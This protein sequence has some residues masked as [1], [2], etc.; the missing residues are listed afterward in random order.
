M[1][2]H[3]AAAPVHGY[4]LSQVF[5]MAVDNNGKTVVGDG[6]SFQGAHQLKGN[7]IANTPLEWFSIECRKKFRI[8]FGLALLRSVIGY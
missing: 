4:L 8:C 3:P 6:S 2:S 5:M 1:T 7:N